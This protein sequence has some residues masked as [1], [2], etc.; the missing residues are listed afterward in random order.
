M[1]FVFHHRS[2]TSISSLCTSHPK[3][4]AVQAFHSLPTS[5]ASNRGL[6]KLSSLVSPMEGAGIFHGIFKHRF[7]VSLE[8]FGMVFWEHFFGPRD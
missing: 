4:E 8:F 5:A 1:V 2:I 6:F 7:V 3:A